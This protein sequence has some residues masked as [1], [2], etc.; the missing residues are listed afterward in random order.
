MYI[1]SHCHLSF[2]ELAADHPGVLERMRQ[3][4]V[5]TALNV[6][7]RMEEFSDILCLAESQPEVFATVGV[8]PD[9]TES[10]EP[11][12]AQL[13]AHAAHPR[14]LAIGETGLD[15]YR[16]KEPLHWQRDRFRVH[17]R[18][19]REVS[20]P[21][22]VHTRCAPEDTLKIMKEERAADADC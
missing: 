17:I 22:V 11:T 2:P 13:V 12:V 8:H 4:G 5:G 16:L 18:A 9:T 10:K 1:D 20:K 15:Y 6:C 3:A 19:A 7:V 21:L 14:V